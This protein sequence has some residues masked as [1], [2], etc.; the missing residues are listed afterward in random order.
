VVCTPQEALDCFLRTRMDLL[1][2]GDH[3]LERTPV[4]ATAAPLTAVQG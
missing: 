3:M 1:V 2:L 4:G